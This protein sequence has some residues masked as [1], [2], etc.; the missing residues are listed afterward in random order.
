MADVGLAS[1]LKGQ[2]ELEVVKLKTLPQ[3][4][5]I[6]LST[7]HSPVLETLNLKASG[8]T[9]E[10]TFKNL[11]KTHLFIHL[12]IYLFSLIIQLNFQCRMLYGALVVTSWTCYGAL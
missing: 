3:L 4:T 5:A 12:F 2:N 10:G 6:G 9:S 8:V 11:L 7:L 1:V